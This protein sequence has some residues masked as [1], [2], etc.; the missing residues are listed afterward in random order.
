MGLVRGGCEVM[1]GPAH[2][3]THTQRDAGRRSAS[4]SRQAN[5][6]KSKAA[7]L[8]LSQQPTQSTS[9][10]L[11]LQ[12]LMRLLSSPCIDWRDT[13]ASSIIIIKFGFAGVCWRAATN[14]R[15]LRSDLGLV[16]SSGM[17]QFCRSIK[18]RD[19]IDEI[20]SSTNETHCD[21]QHDAQTIERERKRKVD[22]DTRE[23]H[24][25]QERG[26]ELM[27]IVRDHHRRV[28]GFSS[29]IIK[30]MVMTIKGTRRSR[31]RARSESSTSPTNHRP[32]IESSSSLT[33]CA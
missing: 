12:T 5:N 29:S 6:N 33:P 14:D 4:T 31:T 19:M 17:M 25:R 32:A 9:L 11:L 3:R 16:C 21:P 8:R 10:R 15:H 18:Q 23:R 26:L 13:Q 27:L 24:M 28:E 20:V 2:T 30:T 7:A 1:V 22:D